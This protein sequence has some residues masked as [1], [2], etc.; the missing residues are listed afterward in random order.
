PSDSAGEVIKAR[1]KMSDASKQT[2]RTTHDIVADGVSKLSDHAI[3]SLPNLQNLKRTV[4]RIRQRNQNPLPLPTSRD[5]IVIDP[6]YTKTARKRTF[7]QFDSGPIDRRILI[8]STKKQLKILGK[9]HSI[10]LDGTFSV[11]P[12]LYFQLYTIHATYLNHIVPVVYVLLPGKTQRLYKEMLQ[13]ITN[14]TP[15][16]DPPNVMVDYERAS[17]NA[18]RNRF[19]TTNLSGCFFHL[20]Q[21]IYRAVLRFGLKTLYSEDSNFAQQIRSI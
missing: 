1:T 2:G 10:Y 11:V 15:N 9:A 5:T 12:E 6:Q 16:C 8:F 19:P 14:L 3:S 17:I 13:Q 4:Q 7:L 20:C 21:S 18:I